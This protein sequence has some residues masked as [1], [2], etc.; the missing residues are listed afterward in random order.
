TRLGAQVTRFRRGL[1]L[2]G[3]RLIHGVP[4]VVDDLK[5]IAVRPKLFLDLILE[6]PIL[7][8]FDEDP[9]AVGPLPERLVDGVVESLMDGEPN[10]TAEQQHGSRENRCVPERET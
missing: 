7:V 3:F 5:E 8:V 1:P 4:T 6:K 9:D 10:R 2:K